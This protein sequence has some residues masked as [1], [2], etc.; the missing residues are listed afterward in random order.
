MFQYCGACGSHISALWI[1]HVLINVFNFLF[2]T[3]MIIFNYCVLL[4]YCVISTPKSGTRLAETLMFPST[5]KVRG[6]AF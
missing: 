4:V 6:D 5:Y 3:S 1:I 2:S